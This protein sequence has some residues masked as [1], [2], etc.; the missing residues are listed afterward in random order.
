MAMATASATHFELHS[1]SPETYGCHLWVHYSIQSGIMADQM[2]LL[3]GEKKNPT[4]LFTPA[5]IFW[6]PSHLTDEKPTYISTQFLSQISISSSSLSHLGHKKELVNGKTNGRKSLSLE[7]HCLQN[8]CVLT[9]QNSN[10]KGVASP[11][12]CYQNPCSWSK[13]QQRARALFVPLPK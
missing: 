8:L 10:V 3:C 13:Q 1:G 9:R 6:S 7:I 4:F 2:Q 12:F 11:P 5:L